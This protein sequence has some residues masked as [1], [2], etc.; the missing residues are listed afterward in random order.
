M[1]PTVRL[2][3]VAALVALAGCGGP[4]RWTAGDEAVTVAEADCADWTNGQMRLRGWP[5]RPLA[6]SPQANARAALFEDCM[7]R[8]GLTLD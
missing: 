5:P 7:T 3:F 4:P 6:D 2:P 1:H 8:R